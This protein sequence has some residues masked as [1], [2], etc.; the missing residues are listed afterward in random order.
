MDKTDRQS[1]PVLP[2]GLGWPPPKHIVFHT[3]RN[4][5]V[6][7]TFILASRYFTPRRRIKPIGGWGKRRKGGNPTVMGS[8]TPTF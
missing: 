4:C 5:P 2:Q 7:N 6:T 3:P 1:H 8:E